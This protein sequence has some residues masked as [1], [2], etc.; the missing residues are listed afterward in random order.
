MVRR[1]YSRRVWYSNCINTK[2]TKQIQEQMKTKCTIPDKLHNKALLPQAADGK[3]SESKSLGI[4]FPSLINAA[5]AV[6][7]ILKLVLKVWMY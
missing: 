4:H 5:S 1:L 7:K 6:D 3:I 2:E